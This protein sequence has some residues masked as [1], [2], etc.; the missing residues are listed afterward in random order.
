MSPVLI[1]KANKSEAETIEMYAGKMN[2]DTEDF[3]IDTFIVAEVESKLVGFARIRKHNDNC[4]EL[5]TLGV[6]KPYRNNKIGSALVSEL[7]KTKK[8]DIY[9]T[10]AIPGYFEKFGF[11][12]TTDFPASLNHKVAFCCNAGHSKDKVHVMVI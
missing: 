3:D 5:S 12:T 6:W 7:L 2:L 11:N 9:L 8:G 10:T 4:N 1:R